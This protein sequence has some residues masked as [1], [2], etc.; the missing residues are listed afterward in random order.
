MT[1]TIYGIAM[2]VAAIGI[3]S[4]M[5]EYVA[6]FKDDKYKLNQFASSGGITSF[7]LGI[8]F[9]AL[10]YFSSGVFVEI[11]NMLNCQV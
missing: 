2:L 3:P 6:E 5:I 10:F 1:S 9:S 8:G 7:L 4:A 11:F